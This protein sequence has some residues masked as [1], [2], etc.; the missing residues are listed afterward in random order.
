MIEFL[1]EKMTN[2][3]A[4]Y[5]YTTI[6]ENHNSYGRISINTNTGDVQILEKDGTGYES[7]LRHA[8]ST[9]LSFY[10]KNYYPQRRPFPG[11]VANFLK[12]RPWHWL[13]S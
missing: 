8:V 9:V 4:I 7:F 6:G 2:S 5:K 1:L 13:F 11:P 12:G 3:I 10:K